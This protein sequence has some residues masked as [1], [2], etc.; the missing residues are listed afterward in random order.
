MNKI[1][2]VVQIFLVA[3]LVVLGACLVACENDVPDSIYFAKEHTPRKTYVRGQDLDF[4]GLLLTCALNGEPVTVPMDS[5]DVTVSG[6]EKD[7]LGTQTVTV[8]YKE[9]TTSFQVTVIPRLQVEGYDANYFVGDSFNKQNGR[10]KVAKDDGTVTTVNMRED[11]VSILNFDSEIPGKKDVTVTYGEYSATFSVNILEVAQ[12]KFNSPSK[13]TYK[14]HETE[15]SVDGGYFTVTSEGGVITK[16]VSLTKEDMEISG[17]D[18]SKATIEN[19]TAATALKQTVSIKY[20]GYEFKMEIS[21][22]YGGVSIVRQYAAELAEVDHTQPISEK[23]GEGA[24][25]AMRE[26]LDLSEDD[27]ALIAEEERDIIV[28]VSTAY[29]YARFLEELDKYS[30]TFGISESERTDANNNFLEYCGFFT[31]SCEK[32]EDMLTALEALRNKSSALNELADFLRTLETEFKEIEITEGVVIDEYLK[33]LY[34]EEDRAYVADLFKQMTDI[35]AELKVVPAEWDKET[36]KDPEIVTAIERAYLRLTTSN[37][38]HLSYPEFYQMISRWRDKNDFYEIIHTHYLYNK[39]Y[40]GEDESYSTTVWEEIPFPGKLQSLYVGIA[41]GFVLTSHMSQNVYDTTE[42][43]VVY[44]DVMKLAEEI[45]ADA[46]PLYKDIYEAI[47]FD[48][49]IDGYLYSASITKLYAYYEVL[50]ALRYNPEVM[51]LIWDG[52]FALVDLANEEGV[53]DL[54]DPAIQK[55]IENLFEDFFGLKPYERHLVM[56]SLYS[57][58][59]SLNVEGYAFDF[60]ENITGSFISLFA[61]YY[62]GE[63]NSVLPESTHELF[64][65]LMIATEQYGIRYKQLAVAEEAVASYITMMEEIIDLYS[66]IPA[67]DKEVF[68]KYVG[69]AYNANLLMYQGVKANAP[70]IESYPLLKEF[71]AVLD[72]YYAIMAEIAK[73]TTVA[74]DNGYYALLFAAYEK[75]CSLHNAILTSD[76]A[77]LLNAYRT[78]DY[79]V[80]NA[81]DDNESNDYHKTLEAVFDLIQVSARGYTVTMTHNDET[82]ESYNAVEYYTEKGLASFFLDCYEVLYNTFCGKQNSKE[83]V[84]SLMAKRNALEGDALAIF[85]SLNLDACYTTAIEAF[86]DGALAG[87]EA[88]S[89]LADKL[90]AA[91]DAYADYALNKD[92]ADKKT[93]WVEAWAAV[94]SALTALGTATENFEALLRDMY[95]CYL[96][97]YNA[98]QE[99]A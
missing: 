43:M 27:E 41:N 86:F 62:V 87:D 79:I 5:P 19:R 73:D 83:A 24:M 38:S 97:A 18:P 53:V 26:F 4:T 29:A 3:V 22:R 76:D 75:A 77:D 34:L 32:Y 78:F 65:K 98:M 90:L 60:S 61:Y 93:A 37:F 66:K 25:D 35:F 63:E 17:F 99:A 44:R 88:T 20:L 28:R 81:S 13:K 6:Y 92:D 54:T 7:T 12:V 46:N 33:S 56:C 96:A 50:G 70:A 84:L 31:I 49:L 55:A 82:K 95:D 52:Y 45:K 57:N 48:H 67:A 85:Y 14:S 23:N 42:F 15:F 68:N 30:N 10:I 72:S 39:T 89:T 58:Y 91:E 9:K 94:E 8:T 36:L 11:S 71:K 80:L 1:T 64:Q 59:G 16:T 69:V 2:K 21:I 51:N 40:S 47:D 74:K